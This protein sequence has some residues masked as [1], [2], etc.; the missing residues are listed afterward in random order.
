[1]VSIISCMKKGA[2]KN[3]EISFA[4]YVVHKQAQNQG[5]LKISRGHLNNLFPAAADGGIYVRGRHLDFPTLKSHL[6]K[7]SE[8]EQNPVQP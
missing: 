3:S 2:W 8:K 5:T 7:I 6:Q 4:I 1:M